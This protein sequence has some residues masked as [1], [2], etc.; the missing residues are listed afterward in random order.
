MS[1]NSLL[2][3]EARL[4]QD[5]R[6]QAFLTQLINVSRL[7][8]RE[9]YLYQLMTGVP[10]KDLETALMMTVVEYAQAV[11]DNLKEI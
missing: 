3:P 2:S 7:Y 8:P 4:E 10:F 9:K 1:N 6:F 5:E 11:N